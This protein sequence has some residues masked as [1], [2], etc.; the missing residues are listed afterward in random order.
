MKLKKSFIPVLLAGILVIGHPS[1]FSSPLGAQA[2]RG[3]GGGRGFSGSSSFGYGKSS[4][5]SAPTRGTWDRSG[6]GLFGPGKQ[7]PA[8]DSKPSSS[9]YAK[10]G[11]GDR[12]GADQARPAPGKP[13]ASSGY[14]KPSLGGD[15]AGKD[16]RPAGEKA[17]GG[18]TKPSAASGAKEQFT[19]GTKFDKET[20]NA[21][22]SQR[23]KESL[24]SYKAEQS[25]YAKP[26]YKVDGAESSPLAQKVKVPP[27]FGYSDHYKN[28]DNFYRAQGYQAPSYAFG[29]SPTFGIFSG[30]FLFWMLDHM[31]D[32]RVAAAAYHH[33]DDPGFKKWREDLESQ[34]K[35]NAEL[36]TKL[37]E[38]DKQIASMK[39]T[40][41]DPSYLPPGVPPEVAL[42]ESVLANKKPEKPLLRFASG[43]PGGWY[44]KFAD[45]LKKSSSS[46]DVKTINTGGSLENLKLLVD[47]QADLA[48]VQSDALALVHKKLPGKNL[49]T[50]QATLYPEIAQLL[51][52]RDSGIKSIDDLDP[53]KNLVFVGPKGSGTAMTWDALSEQ[54]EALKKIPVKHADYPA[55]L[56][57]VV[58]NPKA[59]M[60]FVGGLKNE[61]LERAEKMARKS[62]NL[63][64]VTLGDRR[65]ADKRDNNGNVIYQLVSIPKD[66]Y[67]ALEKGWLFSS[68]VESL[69]VQAVLVLR[70]EWAEKN[71]PTAMDA[72]SLAVLE[73]KPEIQRQVNRAK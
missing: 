63:R 59:L 52:N 50:E 22:K 17:S 54:S 72:L 45:M 5:W 42:S 55:A 70:T 36:K 49:I 39:G 18:Y 34:A 15:A 29:S 60:L 9:G 31:S 11:L 66:A 13:S 46:L 21:Q 32:R 41:K 3:F 20:I 73:S 67:P 19:G 33:S 44:A 1:V 57:E 2:G 68:D 24:D 12:S 40:P 23:A 30:L 27:G 56:A 35:D 65:F 6:G 69:A 53:K 47:G 38:M 51:A 37:A 48:I 16:A 43:Q 64:L 8:G 14:S 71:G 7:T 10:P 26:E 25:K 58:K 62:G 28:R 61:F 4:S